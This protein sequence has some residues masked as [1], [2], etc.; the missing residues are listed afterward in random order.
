MAKKSEKAYR[1]F[2]KGLITEANKLT[3]PDNASIDEANF[4]LRRDGSRLRRLGIDYEDNHALISSGLSRDDLKV[5]KQSFH[6]WNNPGGDTT[7]SLGVVRI[8]NKLWFLNMLSTTPS[9]DLKNRG[10]SI[11]IANLNNSKIDVS[12]LN[13]KCIIVSTDLPDPV[14]LTYNST[15]DT[16]TQTIIDIKVR[17]IWGVQDNLNID[18]RPVDLTATHKYN[19]RNQGWNK[20]IVTKD[21]TD[22]L[23]YTKTVL[24][25][26]PSNADQWTLGKIS[27]PGDEAYEKYDPNVLV[28]NSNSNY[29]IAKGSFIIDAFKRGES[30]QSVSD[31][32]SGLPTDRETGRISTV[33]SYAQRVFYSGIG[34]QVTGA[35]DRSPNYSGY[36]FFSKVIQSNDDFGKCYQEADPTDPGINDLVAS[37][38]GTAHI[39]DCTKIIKIA[40]SRSSLLI[41][42]ENGV[43]ELFGDTGGFFATSFQVSK[44][45]TNGVLNADSVVDVNGTFLYWSKA[46]VYILTPDSVSGR[47]AAESLSLTSIQELFLDIPSTGKNFCKGFYDEKENQVRWLYNDS[48]DYTAVN[49]VNNYT[50]ELIYD[51]TLQAWYKNTIDNVNTDPYIADYIEIPTYAIQSIDTKNVVPYDVIDI[52]RDSQFSFLTMV[53]TSFTLS[54]YINENFVDW[55]K[56]DNVGIDYS[57]YL[58]T[59]Y[60]L[61]G[62]IMQ[63]KQIPYV[64]F[65]FI[66]TEDGYT[67]VTGTLELKNQSSCKVQAQW[68]WTDSANSGKWGKEF[69]AYRLLR[70]YI[71]SGVGDSFDYGDS[72]IVTKNKLRGSGKCLSLLIKSEKNKDMHLLGWGHPVVMNDY[73]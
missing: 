32:K 45:S 40:A 41:F 26:Y 58:V 21:G 28:K 18:T 1:S 30:R 73:H 16:V 34:S 31:V 27:N 42:A 36:I 72:V 2:I 29:Q 37:D 54:K 68:E 39:P 24:G 59:G 60:E 8:K 35:D 50:K 70:P 12:V 55:Y 5:S 22:A 48:T 6:V 19:L 61:F 20:N 64:F 14:L 62:D 25:Q 38:G 57:S 71:P 63:R 3:F 49:Y 23:A 7:V 4:V 66:R 13:N 33:A 9:K 51:L 67:D 69:Q 53:G 65:Y 47:F 56:Y 46:G 52:N 15:T 43:W 11:T 10:N 44:I 17:D